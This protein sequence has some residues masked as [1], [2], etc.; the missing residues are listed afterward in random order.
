MRALERPPVYAD[1]NLD[2]LLIEGLRTLGFDVLTTRE[3][4][5]RQA[6]DE[7]QLAEAAR[8]GRVLLSHDRRDFRRLH[9]QW[10][11]ASRAHA[12]IATIPQAGPAARRAV[13]A[14]LVID[15]MVASGGA[16]SRFA[17]WGH[18]QAELRRGHRLEGHTEHDVQV[19]L[20]LTEP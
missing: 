13:R 10:A 3:A 11:S 14:A 15:W 2:R 16:T 17:A 12:G 7:R 9:H 8:R 1:E 18:V 19:A 5:L 4:G 6:S 20:G